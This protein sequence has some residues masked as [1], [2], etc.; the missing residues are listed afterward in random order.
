VAKVNEEQ[1]KVNIMKI[2][3]ERLKK[4]QTLLEKGRDVVSI[5]NQIAAV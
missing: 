5:E 1:A 4:R 2:Q 3:I